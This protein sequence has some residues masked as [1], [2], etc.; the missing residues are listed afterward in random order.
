MNAVTLVFFTAMING[1][2]S[3]QGPQI[4][5]RLFETKKEC[6]EFVNKL[7]QGDVVDENYEFKFASMDGLMFIGGCYNE[8]EFKELFY[9]QS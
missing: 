4:S 5:D 1:P 6:A 9:I 7:V 8:Q 3:P 2:F